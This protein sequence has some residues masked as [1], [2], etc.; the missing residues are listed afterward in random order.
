MLKTHRISSV[1]DS[2]FAP[3]WALYQASF[4]INEKRPSPEMLR[5]LGE[6]DFYWL[7]LEDDEGLVGL[8]SYWDDA[9]FIYGEHLAIAESRRGQ[10]LGHKALDLLAKRAGSKTIILE[11]ELPVDEMTRARIRFYESFGFVLLPY[12]HYQLPY[13]LC[14]APTPLCLMSLPDASS[15]M[16]ALF[17]TY[18]A[19]YPMSF[20]ER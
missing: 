6:P 19:Q 20:V 1:D 3:L 16:I 9:F 13:R 11:V 7:S 12:D 18:L 15:S 4:P 14:D 5:A 2:R 8:L 17:E 10:G